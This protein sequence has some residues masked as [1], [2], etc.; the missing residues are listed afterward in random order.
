[1][2]Q[3]RLLS[4]QL[5][6]QIAA[7][8]V[9]ERP[10]SVVKELVENALDAGA[11]QVEVELEAGGKRRIVVADDG[12]GMDGDDALLAFDRHAT[13][14]IS[15]F[16]ELERVA[17]LGFRGEAL[18]SIASVSRIDLVTAEAAGEGLR[19][20]I[21]GGRVLSAEPAA[22]RRGTRI[23]VAS[24]FFNVPAR[25]KFLKTPETELRRC[26]EI[27]QGYA[28]AHAGIGFRVQHEGQVLLDALPVQGEEGARR[29]IAQIYGRELA[30]RLIEIP[31]DFIGE[32][33]AIWGFI[34][35]A[36]TARGRR[37]AIFVNG[38]LVKDRVLM[39]RFYQAVRNEWHGEDFPSLF[40]FIDVD[41][42]EVDVN[43]HPQKT[44]VRFRSA[45]LIDR[46]QEA[47]ARTL[48]LARREQASPLA[49]PRMLP[50]V[51]ATWE[52]LGG[53][54]R[55]EA[56]PA[57]AAPADEVRQPWL[58]YAS[59]QPAP[60]ENTLPL[61]AVGRSAATVDLPAIA[62][63]SWAIPEP[64]ELTISRAPL[65]GRGR[66]LSSFRLLGQ[67]KGS[68]VLLEGH[69]GLY[70]IDQH[71]AHERILFE[72]LRRSFAER[73]AVGQTLLEPVLLQLSVAE[74]LRL[75]ELLPALESSGFDVSVLS[76][77]SVALRAFPEPLS[78]DQAE[79]LIQR[80]ATTSGENAPE[81]VQRQLID[82]LAA[83]RSC[84]AAI[85]IHRLMPAEEMERLV[86]DLFACE[87]PFACPHGRPT[88][89]LLGD[90]DLE[91]RFG[92]RG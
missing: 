45:A 7:G 34:G 56:S 57:G 9:V 90:A 37:S 85:K 62:K 14:K 38:R 32:R 61:P 39:A 51:P 16:A 21:E 47:M 12:R 33:E 20:R 43:V 40:L 50:T 53:Q 80:L 18:S 69:D 1:V 19:V 15:T 67:Y 27:V 84:K 86:S 66:V 74:A 75:Q 77:G 24:L 29:R 42:G 26:L 17:T 11:T 46:I 25:R 60:V 35:D 22:F 91:R 8:E 36:R 28:L 76:G 44:E 49:Q 79:G 13:S 63:P 55:R 68:L 54:A 73:K 83:D 87:Q 41:G 72:R 31:L 23:E 2:A 4:D 52:G 6:S 88:V 71:A 3:I 78:V 5:I 30:D 82:E 64:R 58:G 59:R 89:L 65:S 92:R 48:A 70:L 81:A 10:S